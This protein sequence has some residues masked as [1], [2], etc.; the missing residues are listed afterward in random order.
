MSMAADD[1]PAGFQPF[2]VDEGFVERIGP[3]YWKL[4]GDHG[5]LGFRVLEHHLNPVG[6]CHGGMMMS[7][8]DMAVGFNLRLASGTQAFPP[9][10]QLAYDFLQPGRAGDWLQS[11][12][13]FTHTTPRMGFANGLLVGSEG[14]VLRCNGICRLPRADDPRFGT[15]ARF[16]RLP[17]DAEKDNNDTQDTTEEQS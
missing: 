11:A 12:I 4:D 2:P 5:V 1:I 15:G 6:I 17:G 8:M 10:I 7:V 14:P 3:L 16:T 9:S 13:D